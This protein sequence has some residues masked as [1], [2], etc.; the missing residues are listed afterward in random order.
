M[1]DIFYLI[2]KWWK[3]V[4]LFVAICTVLVLAILL[5]QTKKYLGE[6][7]A[8]PA[9]TALADKARVFNNNI[10]ALYS[11]VGTPDELDM[12][13][14]TAQLDTIYLFQA[15]SFALANYYNIS[16]TNARVK[17]AQRLHHHTSVTKSGYGELKV[18]VWDKDPHMAAHLANAIMQKLQS[19]HQAV[20]NENNISTLASLRLSQ[21]RL[22]TSFDSSSVQPAWKEALR[23]KR[24]E[25]YEELINDYSL[26]A[27]SRPLAL[28]TIENAR[29]AIK[30]DKPRILAIT[31]AT[32]ALSFIFALL[33]ILFIEKTRKPGA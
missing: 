28:L 10:E 13:L 17:A 1:P 2:S 33:A 27:D 23:I 29:A 24:L 4:I 11:S 9:N 20:I 22:M 31:L 18:K 5:L 16:G 3:Q 12:I 14:G 19:M 30:P 8:I 6:A 25:Q 26:M 21:Q 15:D 32:F 7:T